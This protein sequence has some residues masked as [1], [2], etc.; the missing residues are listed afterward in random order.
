MS[1]KIKEEFLHV[2][3][4]VGENTTQTVLQTTLDISSIAPS[5]A[6]V[7]WV[8]GSAVITDSI[9]GL[10]KVNLE[11]YIDLSLV[12]MYEDLEE[13]R[14]N[15]H[16]VPYRH[17]ITFSDYVEVIGAEEDMLVQAQVDL[18]G[19]EWELQFDQRTVNVD[20]LIQSTAKVKQQSSCQ[21]VT[22]AS[23]RAPKKLVVDDGVFHVQS[24]LK[25]VKTAQLLDYDITLPEG[26]VP[27]DLILDS[28]F[29]PKE[30]KTQVTAENISISGKL[31]SSLIYLDE[32]GNVQ[33]CTM[34]EPVVFQLTVPNETKTSELVVEPQIKVNAKPEFT[35]PSSSYNLYGELDIK[36]TLYE[37]KYVRLVM[38]M[39]CSGCLIETRTRPVMLD[40]LVNQKTQKSSARGVV[41]LGSNYPPIR[42]ILQA[43]GVIKSFDY[44]IDE[45]KVLVEGAISLDI[46]YLAHTEEELK[47]L[48]LAKFNNAIPFQQ[49]IV[50]GGVQPGMTADLS[51]TVDELQLD[52][53]NRETV[54]VDVN[55]CSKLKVTEPIHQEVVVEALEIPPLAEEPPSVTYIFVK[56]KDTLWKLSRQYHT[57]VEAIIDS[58]SWL[59]ERD[60]MAIKV[61]DRLCVPRK[62]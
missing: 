11:G 35:A 45:D 47:P 56:N 61:G 44:R 24:Q 2:E 21:V 8:K 14:L 41:E 30:L 49:S 4:L 51:I 15:Y 31:A 19:I 59:R 42:E 12:Y 60:D 46:V 57:S 53:I 16:I 20:V 27:I 62:G 34:E 22:N 55:Y 1:L 37:S 28:H 32:N 9:V 7:V 58:N 23:I 10:D 5:I 3:S 29:E 40:N 33:Q 25:Q 39:D 36:L 17:A 26:A 52:L 13:S 18:L 48:Y 38:N 6:R 43:E 50:A 54:E